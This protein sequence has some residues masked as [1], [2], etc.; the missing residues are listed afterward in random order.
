MKYE[1]EKH[2]EPQP[3]AGPVKWTSNKHNR[4][5]TLHVC[6][7]LRWK[8]TMIS[9]GVWKDDNVVNIAWQA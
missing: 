9:T 2:L 3:L 6:L 5:K 4:Y 1:V 8:I 7:R